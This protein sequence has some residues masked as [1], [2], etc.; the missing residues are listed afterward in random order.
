MINKLLS[1]IFQLGLFRNLLRSVPTSLL[2]RLAE[3][4]AWTR[5]EGIYPGWRFAVEECKPT[6]AVLLRLAIWREFA[7]RNLPDAPV[8]VPWYQG[9]TIYLRLGNDQSRCLYVSGSFEPNELW[10]L[11]EVLRPGMCFVDIGA[12]EGFY[13]IYA[14]KKA[15]TSGRV[16]SF[17]PSPR[18]RP[19][20]ER[21]VRANQL[22]NVAISPLA[23]ADA[24]G[25]AVLNLADAEHNGQNTLGSFGHQGVTCAES[26]KV[27]LATLDALRESGKIP[28]I[29]VIKMDVEGAELKVLRGALDTLKNDRP[30]ILMELFDAALRG[31]GASAEEVI[32]FLR[33][34]GYAISE[35][36]L[37]SGTLVNMRKNPPDSANIVARPI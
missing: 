6:T 19:W 4:M 12:N 30:L 24:P 10:Y 7:A 27:E 21:N 31:Q 2:V 5:E 23:L 13:S 22:D 18:E 9:L 8:R 33:D 34:I 32:D 17:E 11:G 3:R 36:D 14:A 35:F 29:D 20:L 26:V 1:K 16:F 37:G 28:K 15:G 25:E